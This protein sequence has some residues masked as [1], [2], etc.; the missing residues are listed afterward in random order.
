MGESLATMIEHETG[1]IIRNQVAYLPAIHRPGEIVTTYRW[2]EGWRRYKVTEIVEGGP[3]QV[4]VKEC[5]NF[6]S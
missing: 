6:W 5:R 1:R 3:V 4:L 2:L